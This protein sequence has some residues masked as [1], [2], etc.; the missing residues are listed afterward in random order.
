MGEVYRARDTRLDRDVAVKVLPA[1]VAG[2]ADRLARFTREAR[3]LA[4]LNHPHIA[5]IYGIEEVRGVSAL[6]MELVEG[7]DL[8]AHI[9]RS[10]ANAAQRRSCSRHSRS[11]TASGRPTAVGWPMCPTKPG[12]RRYSCRR[13]VA[14]AASGWCPLRG[15]ASLDGEATVASCT[16]SPPT[17]SWRWT[18]RPRVP[19]SCP[20]PHKCCSA[21]HWSGRERDTATSS[22]TPRPAMEA[23][24]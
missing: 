3:T 17:R 18:R 24:F 15:A 1:S 22:C 9:A 19:C 23:V 20:A 5:Q 8:S 14:A 12:G 16:S 6:V 21:R 10:T 2:D 7:E 13:R 11:R 4:A